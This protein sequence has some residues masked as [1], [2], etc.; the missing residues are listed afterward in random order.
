MNESDY[1]TILDSNCL[2]I[3]CYKAGEVDFDIYGIGNLDDKVILTF[4]ELEERIKQARAH[5]WGK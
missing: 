1:Y 5:L 4:K 3:T 2:E